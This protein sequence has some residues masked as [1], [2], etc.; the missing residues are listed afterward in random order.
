MKKR[1]EF[2]DFAIFISIAAPDAPFDKLKTMCDWGNW[3]SKPCL[4]LYSYSN[5][6]PR[7]SLSMIVCTAIQ[8]DYWL[9]ELTIAVFDEGSLKSDPKRSQVVIDSLMADMLDQ[10]YTR[11]KSAVIQAHD[12]IFRRVSQVSSAPWHDVI[13]IWQFT[14]TGLNTWQVSLNQPWHRPH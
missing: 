8:V 2:C 11:P 13:V 10:A 9:C 4:L 14:I 7:S 3:V 5:I 1:V 12:D 6:S